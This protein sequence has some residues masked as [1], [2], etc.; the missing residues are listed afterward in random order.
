MSAPGSIVFGSGR[1]G[2]SAGVREVFV[3]AG[4]FDASDSGIVFPGRGAVSGLVSATVVVWAGSSAVGERTSVGLTG[5]DGAS[6]WVVTASFSRAGSLA[7]GGGA[8]VCAAG[9]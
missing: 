7:V 1:P 8:A 5:E 4:G 9:I 2:D 3:V 6:S